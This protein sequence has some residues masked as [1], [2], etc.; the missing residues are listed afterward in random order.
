MS[1]LDWSNSKLSDLQDCAERF[2]RK[3]VEGEKVPGTLRMHAGVAPH[4]VMREAH[5]RQIRAKELWAASG[6]TDP[7]AV[8]LRDS[9]PSREEARDLAADR[10]EQSVVD[11]VTL[12]PEERQRAR[13]AIGEA[14]DFAVD[15]SAGYVAHVAPHKDPIA[16]ERKVTVA[17]K[18]SD[19]RVVGR[20]DLI[21]NDPFV[22]RVVDDLKTTRASPRKNAADQS[23]QLT[24]YAMLDGAAEGQLPDAVALDYMVRTPKRH[25][26]YHRR[27]TS[28]RSAADVAALVSRINTAIAAVQAGV[29][30]PAQPGLSWRC[31][32][33]YCEFWT[34]CKYVNGAVAPQ[35][36][37]E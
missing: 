25:D 3:Y 24:M 27:L 22:G 29:F 15:V 30:V 36:E 4:E 6:D 12:L 16:V 9:L 21:T 32:P 23:Q 2:R 5:K 20:I 28:T 37:E 11:G 33:R 35:A 13:L 18:D 1:A 19:V 8:V 34:T 31:D 14:K 17:P 7:L 26:V 10:F